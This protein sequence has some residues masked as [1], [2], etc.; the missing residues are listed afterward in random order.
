MR[1]PTVSPLVAT[2]T[3][4]LAAAAHAQETPPPRPHI[5]VTGTGEVSISPDMAV[6]T[7]AVTREAKSARAALDAENEAMNAVIAAM[8]DANVAP[9]DLQTSGLSIN[10]RY[11]DPDGKNGENERRITGYQVTNAL[12]VRVRDLEKV[13]TLI[14]RSVTLGVNQGGDITF[15]NEDMSAPLENARKRAV[16]DAMKR[17]RTLTEAAGVKLGN[18]TEIGEQSYDPPPMPFRAKAMRMDAAASAVPVEA[19]ENSYRVQVTMT[20]DIRQ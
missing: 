5:S 17:A 6:M 16:A 14:D 4:A 9:R 7:L 20:F 13:G 2:L 10:P 11:G 12:T 15:T 19:G 8:K 18:I 1:K 3:L